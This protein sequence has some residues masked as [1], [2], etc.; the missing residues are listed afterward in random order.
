MKKVKKK[1]GGI[2][3]KKEKTLKKVL[4]FMYRYYIIILASP[5]KGAELK[6][7]MQE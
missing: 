5:V 6:I 7:K 4:T 1:E 3:I 2:K